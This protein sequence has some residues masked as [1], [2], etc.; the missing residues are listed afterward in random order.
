MGF[1][2]IFRLVF[3]MRLKTNKEPNLK[4]FLIAWLMG[5][6]YLLDG[7]VAILSIGRVMGEFALN[8]SRWLAKSRME[9]K[10]NA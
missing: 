5:L 9:S 2:H 3:K 10:P 4:C 7:L 8:T 1:K 6:A